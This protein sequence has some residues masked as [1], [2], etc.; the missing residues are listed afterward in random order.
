L[1]TYTLTAPAHRWSLDPEGVLGREFLVVTVPFADARRAVRG[2]PFNG[3]TGRGEQRVRHDAQARKLMRAVAKHR[4]TPAPL[5]ASV[6]TQAVTRNADGTVTVAVP[7]GD[8]LKLVDGVQ[9]LAGLGDLKAALHADEEHAA[10]AL[11]DALP[12]T[13]TVYLDGDPQEDFL[14]LQLGKTVD[15]NQLCVMRLVRGELSRSRQPMLEFAREVARH[16]NKDPGSAFRTHIAFDSRTQAYLKFKSLAG[17]GGADAAASLCGLYRVGGDLTAERA[18]HFVTWAA[19]TVKARCPELAKI[20]GPLCPPP[21]GPVAAACLLVG[22]ATLTA[23]RALSLGRSAPDAEDADKLVAACLA[24]FKP[25]FDG[26]GSAQ[27]K[28]AAMRKLAAHFLNDLPEE[29][30]QGIPKPLLGTL[31]AAAFGLAK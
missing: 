15:S 9:R 24:A 3:L 27:G 29:M 7:E 14:N 22:A 28:R 31:S 1:S 6:T 12:V 19:A 10:A 13:L 16:L 18:A 25:P 11:V 21:D 23:Y 30:E 4:Y 17:A 2:D 5:A 8:P 20:G 26:D